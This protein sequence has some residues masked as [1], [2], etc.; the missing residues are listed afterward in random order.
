M[1][2]DLTLALLLLCIAELVASALYDI[3]TVFTERSFFSTTRSPKPL[4]HPNIQ[5][6]AAFA[7]SELQELSDSG[8]YTTLKLREIE[9]AATEVGDFHYVIHLRLALASPYFRS[10]NATESFEMMVMQSKP[11]PGPSSEYERSIAIDEFPVMDEDAIEEFWIR[12]VEKRRE[13]RRLLFAQW[14]KEAKEDQ[15]AQDERPSTPTQVQVG[16]EPPRKKVKLPFPSTSPS[17]EPVK[18]R[19]KQTLSLDDLHAMPTKQLRRL[20]SKSSVSN[21]LRTAITSILDERWDQ[22][23]QYEASSPHHDLEEL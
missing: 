22:I 1:R 2:V 11:I 3:E 12:M 13:E 6:A 18:S 17:A 4:T 20:L 16:Q 10:K 15:S 8:I 21:E 23:E 7:V 9:E 14:K 19:P 5:A